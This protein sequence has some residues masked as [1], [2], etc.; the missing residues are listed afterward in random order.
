ME[1]V[2]EERSELTE[3]IRTTPATMRLCWFAD[4]TRV[5]PDDTLASFRLVVPEYERKVGI[6][7]TFGYHSGIVYYLLGR[8]GLITAEA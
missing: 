3:L 4:K 6:T 5:R 2:D 7:S 8:A 1:L